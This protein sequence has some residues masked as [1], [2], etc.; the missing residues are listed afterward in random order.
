MSRTGAS[1]PEYR[2][3]FGYPMIR[4]ERTGAPDRTIDISA[5]DPFPAL[6]MMAEEV[7]AVRGKVTAILPEREV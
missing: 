4:V 6:E 3:H 2:L 7:A 1:Q 5:G